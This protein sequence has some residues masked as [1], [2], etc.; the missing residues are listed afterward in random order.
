M[1]EKKEIIKYILTT[2]KYIIPII[3]LMIGILKLILINKKRKAIKKFIKYTLIS[4]II[5]IVSI[6]IEYMLKNKYECIKCIME[7]KCEIKE[8]QSTSKEP[9]QTIITNQEETNKQEEQPKTPQQTVNNGV[10]YIDGILIVN[11]TYSIP[12]TYA[13]DNANGY[14]YCNTCLTPET[15]NAFNQMQADAN[16]L[17]LNLY[18]SSGYR[19]YS[20]QDGLYT[21]YV[22][23]D[24]K[25]AADTYSARPGHSEHQTGLA[26][27]LNTI[28]DSFANT[29]EGKWVQDNCYKYGLII[30]YPKGKENITGYQYESWHL[31]YIGHELAEKLYNN[32]N[33]I[34]LEEHFNLTSRYS[35]V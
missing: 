21:N 3:V 2:F 12:S 33:W 11:K 10:T 26:F 16:A 22:S 30:R 6:L 19:S 29:I 28:D 25:Q 4:I 1:C 15:I 18:I 31:R 14:S 34:T 24:G 35:D 32:G 8:N 9:E 20:Y 13:P 27:D 5:L 7:N 23:R 17:G